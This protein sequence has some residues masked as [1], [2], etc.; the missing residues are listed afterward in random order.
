LIKNTIYSVLIFSFLYI[1]SSVAQVSSQKGITIPPHVKEFHQMIQKE[2]SKGFYAEK[3]QE[4]KQ[5]R[6]KI[7]QGLLPESTL[8]TDTVNAITLLGQ[9]PDL[10]G[11]YTQQEFQAKLYDGPNPTGTITDYYKEVSY[12]QL[13]FSG[14]AQGWYTLPR[15]LNDYVGTNNG[16]GTNGGP[17]FVWELLQAADPT[18]NFAD[19]IQYYD[20]AGKPHIGFIAIVH[21]GAGAEAGASNIW[22]HRWSF[23]NYSNQPFTTNDIDP[24]SGKNVII[25]G[26]YAIM[27]ER[28]GSSNSNGSLIEIGVFA[29][30]FGHIFGLPDLYDTDYSSEGLGNWCLMSAGSWGGNDSSPET[31]T[32]MSAWCKIQL[33]WVTPINFTSYQDSLVVPNV[34]ENPVVYRMW[35]NSTITNQY[36]LVENRQKIGFDKN[37]RNSGFLIFHVDDSQQGNQNENRY[38][39]DLEQADGLRNLNNNQNRGDAGDPFP[40][41]TNNKRFDW[42]TNPNSK[43]YSLQN[44][45]VSVRNIHKSGTFMIGDFAIGLRPGV[46]AYVDPDSIDFGEVEKGTKSTIKTINVANYGNQSLIITNIPSSFAD[47]NFVSSFSFP[48]TI[49]SMD[50]VQLEFQFS[51]STTGNFDVIYPVTT[52]D[53]GFTGIR[54]TG[55]GYAISAALEKTIY[56]S[57][58]VQNSGDLVT[59]DPV[60]GTGNVIGSTFYNEIKS[61]S[62]NP[63]DGKLY[64][65]ISESS[66]AKFLKLNA[67]TGK[68][69]HLFTFNIPSMAAIAFDTAGVL[70]GITRTG[71]LYTINIEDGSTTFLVKAK[72]SYL[73][74]TFNPET[75]EL[76]AT[77]R[78]PNLPNKDA[79]FKVNISTGDTTIVGHT[80]LGKQT[81]DIIFD[82][83]NNLYGVIGSA[84]EVSDFISINTSTGAGNIIGSIGIKNILGLAYIEKSVTDIDENQNNSVSPSEFVL[85]QNYPNPFNPATTINFSLPVESEVRL[86]IYDILGQEVATLINQQMTTGSHSVNWNAMDNGRRNVT[87]GIYFYKLTANGVNGQ[88]FQDIKKMILIK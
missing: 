17:R 81:N 84:S 35:K 16:L 1:T 79:I 37:L 25:D 47:F 87:S 43:D 27:P 71:D 31:P 48:L 62:I 53:S 86:V 6:E 78:A 58:G 40:G 21:A 70:Y 77:S 73:G 56:A 68:A 23:R 76:W 12:D 5:T 52:N 2:Y 49:P 63:L 82:D 10:S 44:T 50:S 74:M 26:D 30:E 9:Y 61:V 85:R 18:L 4:R 67:G 72:G 75:N 45:F 46:F 19:Y 41:S 15:P 11:F 64:G 36:F 88:K 13:H 20:G 51:P 24:V 66:Y 69:H 34:E 83:N 28:N 59:I 22:S 38:K 55:T 3:F 54:L 42:D 29:H 32:H 60:T 8:A 39:V 80:R 14:D 57:S 7:T 33:G 65:I